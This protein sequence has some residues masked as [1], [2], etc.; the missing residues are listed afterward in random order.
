MDKYNIYYVILVPETTSLHSVPHALFRLANENSAKVDW[1]KT[2]QMGR[3]NSSLH[4][5]DDFKELLL[6]KLW[7][8]HCPQKPCFTAVYCGK[9]HLDWNKCI[10]SLKPTQSP[11]WFITVPLQMIP[12]W[13]RFKSQSMLFIF[14]LS[15]ISITNTFSIAK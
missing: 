8:S 11:R 1:L 9:R 14:F 10:L 13:D 3:K 5:W 2:T 4:Y 7:F 12:C 6:F 15:N